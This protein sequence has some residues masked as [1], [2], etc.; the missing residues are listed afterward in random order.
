MR[1]NSRMKKYLIRYSIIKFELV[2]LY[3]CIVP[4]T[5]LFIFKKI[6]FV[7]LSFITGL[8][9]PNISTSKAKNNGANQQPSHYFCGCWVW[10]HTSLCLLHHS[11][12]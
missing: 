3:V 9:P 7:N 1:G 12:K 2:Q 6:V 5:A 8:H 4:G 11:R 10:I